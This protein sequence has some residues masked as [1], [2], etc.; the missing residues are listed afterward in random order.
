VT[1]TVIA[2]NAALGW[3]SDT[4]AAATYLRPPSASQLCGDPPTL[5]ALAR[6]RYSKRTLRKGKWKLTL[7]LRSSG[8]GQ[9]DIAVVGRRKVG[10]RTTSVVV[11]KLSTALTK[12]GDQ[13][14]RLALPVAARKL[15]KYTL[16]VVTTAPDGKTRTTNTL[17]LEVRR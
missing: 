2:A 1:F 17:K 6:L 3:V 10:R 16:R 13:A 11:A 9:A 7:K 8:I 12:P 5:E 15:G 14:L 4:P